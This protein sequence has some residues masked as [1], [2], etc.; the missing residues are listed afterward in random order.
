MKISDLLKLRDDFI[1]RINLLT[2]ESSIADSCEQLDTILSSN[3]SIDEPDAIGKI[4]QAITKI[5]HLASQYSD[6][7]NELMTFLTD[8]D[9]AVDLISPTVHQD[10]NVPFIK[11]FRVADDKLYRDFLISD[12]INQIIKSTIYKISDWHFPGMQLGCR[13]NEYTGNLVG[14]DPLYLCDI[15]PQA[16]D[17]AANQFNDVYGKRLR[18]Y[19][20]NNHQ[21]GHLPMNQFGF[22][23]SW[24]FFNFA[25]LND[26]ELYLAEL[27]KVLRPGGSL[28]LTYNNGDIAESA[29][30]FESGMM[31][32]VPKRKL[33]P[34]CKDLGYIVID[35]FDYD[36]IDNQIK[37]ISWIELR[38]P[39]EL[40]TIKRSQAQGLVGRK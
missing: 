38:K 2:V 28:I 4:Q 32:F 26:M 7:K 9:Q 30:L 35:S 29:R 6:I 18:K 21:L 31:S 40:S 39:G 5:N 22:I 25:E 14:C 27:L 17:D 8:I 1:D 37:T 20:L 36:N 10:V 15:D 19:K 13:N 11:Q 16:I 3:Q 12:Q 33:L 34:I 23:F 24:M